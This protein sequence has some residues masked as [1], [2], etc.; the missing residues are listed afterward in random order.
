M[1]NE[2]WVFA[3]SSVKIIIWIATWHDNTNSYSSLRLHDMP[4]KKSS[5]YSIIL[6]EIMTV[7]W[8]TTF[9]QLKSWWWDIC[10]C[11]HST[12][13]FPYIWRA[14]FVGHSISAALQYVIIMLY[15]HTSYL[16]TIHATE[17][18]GSAGVTF[19]THAVSWKL[20]TQSEVCNFTPFQHIWQLPWYG[21]CLVIFGFW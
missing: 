2:V 5:C 17:V 4:K 8:N 20:F 12:I 1:E 11:V 15:C 13:M 6:T 21:H 19:F 9:K 7:T 10:W 18:L 16:C 3:W 14:R